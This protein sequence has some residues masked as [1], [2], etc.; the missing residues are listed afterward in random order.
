MTEGEIFPNSEGSTSEPTERF[1][2]GEIMAE[3]WG[4]TKGS[5]SI[6]FLGFC[7]LMVASLVVNLAL[8]LAGGL[9]IGGSQSTSLSFDVTGGQSYI[10]FGSDDW[11][12][13][14]L[15]NQISNLIVAPLFAGLI[16]YG[17][18]RARRDPAAGWGDVFVP[19]SR[20]FSLYGLQA[21]LAVFVFIGL[22]LLILPGIYLV[23]AYGMAIPLWVDRQLGIWE[24]LE[25]SRKTV[26]TVWFRYFG[27]GIATVLVFLV[28]TLFT[29]GIGLIWILPWWVL[30]QGVAYRR[31]FGSHPSSVPS[32]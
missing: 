31:L 26:S 27:L 22:L 24:S 3:A 4:L 14:T 28:G 23:V 8:S 32:P 19:Y 15:I 20:M 11:L 17:I 21:L 18:R 6:I 30:V 7:L 1:A 12:A 13:T 25:R 10:D 29:L 5:K 2:I 16:L 9:D